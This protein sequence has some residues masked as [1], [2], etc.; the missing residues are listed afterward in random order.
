M[1]NYNKILLTGA[2]GFIGSHIAEELSG[3]DVT[4]LGC[5]EGNS[6]RCDLTN[7]TPELTEGYDAVVHAAGTADPDFAD[8]L[9]N[10]GTQRLLRALENMPPKHFT[11]IS[12]VLVYGLDPGEDVKEDCFLRPDTVYARSKIRAEKEVEKWCVSHGVS[13]TILRPA[14]AIGR[15]MH[16]EMARMADA[17]MR[18]HYF[19]IRGNKACISLVMADDV[20][21]VVR[22]TF[23]VSGIFN[24]TDGKAHTRMEVADAM[25]ANFS[26]DKR[27]LSLPRGLAVWMLRLFGWMPPMK[28]MRDKYRA[29]TTAATY[30]VAA[31]KQTVDYEP[32]DCVEV[33]ARRHKGYPYKE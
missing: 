1:S 32:Y 27:V 8:A 30:S 25:A 9:N 17:V 26:T 7:V 29:V 18:G 10:G 13:L 20:A 23:G 6:V 5:S 33:M 11:F 3:F 31:L 15:G 4:T 16:G 12:T 22:L 19:H 21:K 14:T 2:T 24:V 28:K